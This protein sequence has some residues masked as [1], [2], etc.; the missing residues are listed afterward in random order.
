M[1]ENE[2]QKSTNAKQKIRDRYRGVD[3]SELTIIP[4]KPPKSAVD[5]GIKRVAPYIRVSTDS[6]EQ[7]SS[8]E[9]QKNYFMEYVNAQPG[10]VLVDIYSDEGISGTQINHRE[11]LQR[12][13]EDCKAG[14]IDYIIT[15]SISRFARNI[16]DCLNMIEDLR[17]LSWMSK[18]SYTPEQPPVSYCVV[19]YIRSCVPYLSEGLRSQ[20]AEILTKTSKNTIGRYLPHHH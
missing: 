2:K 20:K 18:L 7:T 15:K 13:L 8:Y 12:L 5:G 17:N 1:T 3:T 16:V 19:C 4:A 10:W 6:D 14:K 9:L 11:G